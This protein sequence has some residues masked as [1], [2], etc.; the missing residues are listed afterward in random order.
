CGRQHYNNHDD[1]LHPHNAA[2]AEVGEKPMQWN[3][4]LHSYA[5]NYANQRR[6]DCNLQHSNGPYG[7]N[8]FW[9]SDA[10]SFSNTDAVNAWVDEKKYYNY[11]SNSCDA[12]QM[13]GHYTQVVWKNSVNV[14]CARVVCDN[15]KGVF[16]ICSYDPPGNYIG[17]K[18]Y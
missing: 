9:G 10:S 17:E 8:I 18:P 11:N 3:K 7:E 6:G 4:K 5:E 15:S 13:C 14:G 16:I 12:G 2:R 1:F